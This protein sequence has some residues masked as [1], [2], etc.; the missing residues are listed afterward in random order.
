MKKPKYRTITKTHTTRVPVAFNEWEFINVNETRRERTSWGKTSLFLKCLTLFMVFI[1]VLSVFLG[2]DTNSNKSYDVFKSTTS[3]ALNT[4][5]SL[6]LGVTYFSNLLFGS[7]V[8]SISVRELEEDDVIK[9]TLSRG[10]FTYITEPTNNSFT[11]Q[12]TVGSTYFT[13]L[14]QRIVLE[15]ITVQGLSDG[16]SFA[17]N[18]SYILV[19]IR[20]DSFTIAQYTYDYIYHNTAKVKSFVQI[21]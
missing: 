10:L 11:I 12:G 8:S 15:D 4:L 17:P 5:N 14:F 20:G 1:L 18:G 16:S 13:G 6:G 9:L 7:S 21:S 19:Y 2:I 3:Y